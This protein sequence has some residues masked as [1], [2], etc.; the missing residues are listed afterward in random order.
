MDQFND[1]VYMHNTT[2][3]II[4]VG[5]RTSSVVRFIMIHHN[6]YADFSVHKKKTAFSRL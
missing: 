2:M 3:H 1:A 6:G 4:L 5:G